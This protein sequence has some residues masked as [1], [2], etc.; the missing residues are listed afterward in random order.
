MS[1]LRVPGGDR[2]ETVGT[3]LTAALWGVV[4]GVLVTMIAGLVMAFGLLL[5]ADLRPSSS[6]FLAT[7]LSSV[8][9]G[10][11]LAS[12]RVGRGGLWVGALTGVGYAVL[13]WVLSGM[14]NLG[15]L[16]GIG[17]LQAVVSAALVGAVA[18]VIGVN[19]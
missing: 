9:V 14:L 18:G 13:V 17:I 10:A 8:A 11:L 15:P 6:I 1:E 12:R 19:L 5:F 2:A 3:A 7:A 16:T 4:A